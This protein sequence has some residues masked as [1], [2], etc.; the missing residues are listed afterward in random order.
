VTSIPLYDDSAPIACTATGP[1]RAAR[2]EVLRRLHADLER[3]ER[4]QHGMLLHFPDRP[5]IDDDLRRFAR[6]EKACCSF[7]GFAVAAT[8]GGFTLRWDA[9]PAADHLVD[10]LL[11]A[12]EGDD[13]ISAVAGLL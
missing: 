10:A 12:F 2:V 9:P 5:G 3:I 6:D 4:T 7:W 13:P 11:A 1:D 8:S